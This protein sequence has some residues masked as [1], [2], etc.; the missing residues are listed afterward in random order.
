MVPIITT[1]IPAILIFILSIIDYIRR[2]RNRK[3]G[4][5]FGISED[6][7]LYRIEFISCLPTAI[8]TFI[9][10]NLDAVMPSY[11]LT[12]RWY[13]L[14]FHALFYIAY[15]FIISGILSIMIS[16]RNRLIDKPDTMSTTIGPRSEKKKSIIE[17]VLDLILK[18]KNGPYGFVSNFAVRT[19]NYIPL[20]IR[21]R[22]LNIQVGNVDSDQ[23]IKNLVL[24]YVNVPGIS[25]ILNGVLYPRG[26][27]NCDSI[28]GYSDILGLR[29]DI[30]KSMESNLFG[31]LIFDGIENTDEY[32]EFE[33]DNEITKIRMDKLDDAISMSCED[34]TGSVTSV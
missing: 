8:L 12:N 3:I 13:H 31:R 33:L 34:M 19:N 11:I 23:M 28:V 4:K 14:T 6:P 26:L 29:E 18:D 16:L 9:I 25:K 21:D 22:I 17:V 5:Y 27:G 20:G 2:D 1:C 10:G 15:L 7:L 30:V 32:Q 24:Y